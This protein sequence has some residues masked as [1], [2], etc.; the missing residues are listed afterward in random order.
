[1]PQYNDNFSL[2]KNAASESLDPLAL[3]C[4]KDIYNYSDQFLI[5]K[6]YSISKSTGQWSE[7]FASCKITARVSLLFKESLA[8]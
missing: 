7:C 4:I 6:I 1:M 2:I 3:R 5:I 8:V